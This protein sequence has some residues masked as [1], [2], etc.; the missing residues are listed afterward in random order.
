M[1]AEVHTLQPELIAL[2]VTREWLHDH[3]IVV[4]HITDQKQAAVDAWLGATKDALDGWPESDTPRILHHLER[5][6]TPSQ[7]SYT[8]RK[9]AELHRSYFIVR[10]MRIATL[11]RSPTLVGLI[12]V[13][14]QVGTLSMPNNA[15]IIPSAFSDREKAIAWLLEV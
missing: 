10:K 1:S 14:A 7:A 9:I 11:L 4:F 12:R 5:L 13:M 6:G 2:G 15:N 3:K 8:N